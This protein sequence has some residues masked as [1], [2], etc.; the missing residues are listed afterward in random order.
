M[1][2]GRRCKGVFASASSRAALFESSLCVCVCCTVGRLW[3]L[4]CQRFVDRISTIAAAWLPWLFRGAESPG[5]AWH[6]H[7]SAVRSPPL[8]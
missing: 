8:R 4:T 6:L 3:L 5:R 7:C 1:V 2:R